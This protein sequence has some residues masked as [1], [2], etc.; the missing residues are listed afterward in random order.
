MKR[1][2]ISMIAAAVITSTSFGVHATNN[3]QDTAKDAWID[4]KAESVLLFSSQLNS[5][6]INTDVNKGQVILTG[7]VDTEVDKALAEELML[8]VDGVTSV[9]NNLTVIT[10]KNAQQTSDFVANLTDSKVETVVKTRLLFESEVDG[11]DIN[12]EVDNGVVTLA[13]TV[14]S[15]AERE[16]AIAIA[17]NTN[18]VDRVVS[19]LKLDKNS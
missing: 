17:K 7:K 2:T 14:E 15:E 13:G 6:D 5:F 11:L 12:V 18:D 4:G 10:D 16:L 9:D 19:N 3:W 8:S 1:S